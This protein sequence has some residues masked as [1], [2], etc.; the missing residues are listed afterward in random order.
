[1]PFSQERSVAAASQ[2]R[3]IRARARED[4]LRFEA[5]LPGDLADW[6]L[7][8]I[9]RQIFDGP[10]AAVFVFLQE[11]RELEP[12]GDL[13]E[14][15]LRRRISA[16]MNDP[17]PLHSAEEVFDRLLKRLDDW[18]GPATWQKIEYAGAAKVGP[19]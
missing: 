8:L 9:E 4:G 15:L 5:Y 7:G 6:I 14:E 13:R 2:A 11:Q 12:Y 1:M 16:A 17:R 10:D 19:L 3:E 18:Q